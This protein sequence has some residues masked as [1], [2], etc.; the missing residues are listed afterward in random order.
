M[1]GLLKHWRSA[2]H[3]LTALVLLA[4]FGIGGHLVSSLGQLEQTG[5]SWRRI[6]ALALRRLLDSGELSGR[7]ADWYHPAKPEEGAGKGAGR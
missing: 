5:A 1:R 7:E 2:D 6:D 3:R 4:L